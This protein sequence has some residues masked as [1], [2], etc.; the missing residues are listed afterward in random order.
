MRV[1][2]RLDGNGL[3]RVAGRVECFRQDERLPLAARSR[4]KDYDEPSFDQGHVAPGEDMSRNIRH[5][6]NSFIISNMAPQY[7]K[8][9]RVIWRRFEGMGQRGPPAVAMRRIA[10][11]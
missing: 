1:A 2:Y 11:S 7:G 5:N 10:S 8:F 9:N 4:P 6:V 3:N